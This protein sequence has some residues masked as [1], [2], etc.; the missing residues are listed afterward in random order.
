MWRNLEVKNFKSIKHLKLECKKINI[1]I[2]KPN[3]GKSN[4]LESV[5]IF[6][7]S[8]GG[9]E[10]FIRFENLSNLFYDNEITEKIVINFDNLRCEIEYQ[11]GKFIGRGGDIDNKIFS[12][13]FSGEYT[14]TISR[15]YSGISP[16]K[17]YRFEPLKEFWRRETDFLLPPWGENLLQI[18]L[19][20]KSL[21]KLISGI[22]GEFGL[23]I[24]LKPQE[25]KMEVQKEIEDVIISYPYFIISDTLQRIIFH[26]VAIE[27]NTNS[28]LIFEEPESHAFPYYTKFLAERVALDRNNQ[29]FISTHN[30]FFLLSVLEKARVEDVGIFVTYYEDHKTKVKSLNEEEI[31]QILDLDTS[32]FFNLDKFIERE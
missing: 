23:R 20:N 26:L 10:E 30:P 5:G 17:F 1:F 28:V 24:V 22:L 4:I 12:F 11:N 3:T 32:V 13:S 29:Y 9:L 14:G 18:L 27:S 15:G 16:F 2:G 7:L 25:A 31:A 19:S 8:F 21:R 6:S